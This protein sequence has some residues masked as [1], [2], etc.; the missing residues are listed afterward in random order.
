MKRQVLWGYPVLLLSSAVLSSLACREKA[1]PDVP[2]AAIDGPRRGG[3]VITAVLADIA[4]VNPYHPTAQAEE[5][6]LLDLLFPSLMTEQPDYNQHPPSFA[7]RLASSWEFSQDNL[8]L[9]FHLCPEAHWSDG[10]PVTADDVR[11]SYEVQTSPEIGWANADI[12]SSITGVEVV[13]AHTVRFHFSRVYP[14]QLMDAND[15]SIV[16]RHAWGK[17]PFSRWTT[18]EFEP[19]LVTCGPFRL[20]SHVAKQTI[21]LEREPNY[22]RPGLPYLDRLVE[23]V[24]PDVSSQMSQLLAG[25]VNLARPVPP[26]EAQ[27]IRNSPDL[28]LIDLPGRL[29]G[30]LAWNNRDPLF[31]D[32]RVRRALGMAINRKSLVDAVFQGYARPAVGPVLSSFW[33]F[34]KNLAALPFDPRAA[35]QMLADAGWRDTDGDGILDH[36]G[37]PFRFDV[38][39]PSVNTLRGQAA[40]LIQADLARVGVQARPTAVEFTTMLAREESGHYQAMLTAWEEATKVELGTMWAT[41]TDAQGGVNYVGYS[42][43]EVDRLI[44]SVR[45]EPEFAR[46]KVLLDRI[47]ELIVDDQ[48]VTFLY[49]S[50]DLVAISRKIRGADINSGTIFFN[51]DE[52]YWSP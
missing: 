8:T 30:F 37:K 15:G 25:T 31:A 20:V 50:R 41:K 18:T 49:E 11:F 32:R 40:L 51:V 27:R 39:Y 44:A 7:P 6:K 23:R 46:A 34:N 26:S 14:Y 5:V 38:L 17:I 10:A 19:L 42:N 45:D 43:P 4:T 28:E 1:R 3:Q 16:P 35:Q 21:V 52:W 22:W 24:V 36:R 2:S 9:T 12:K 13:D 48:P 47:Q 33:A 29:W